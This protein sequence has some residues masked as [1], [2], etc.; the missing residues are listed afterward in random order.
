[1]M[2]MKIHVTAILNVLKCIWREYEVNTCCTIKSE[3]LEMPTRLQK[4][5]TIKVN[6]G[7][8]T[9]PVNSIRYPTDPSV[10][11]NTASANIQK[12]MIEV[13]MIIW[14]FV[15]L[16]ERKP[17][18]LENGTPNTSVNPTATVID[19]GENCPPTKEMKKENSN[20]NS[21]SITYLESLFPFTI[22]NIAIFLFLFHL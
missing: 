10:I 1:M 7:I 8:W 6:M 4:V 2:K 22:V 20:V 13:L 19:S 3:F 17:I 9:S 12:S 15:V 14:R 11:L 16:I 21:I 5:I 18:I